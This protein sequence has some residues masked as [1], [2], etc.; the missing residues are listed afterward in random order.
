MHVFYKINNHYAY[1]TGKKLLE[2]EEG[3]HFVDCKFFSQPVF[4]EFENKKYY[5]G[6]FINDTLG[7]EILDKNSKYL[8]CCKDEQKKYVV[9]GDLGSFSFDY[10]KKISSDRFY[11][12]TLT[13]GYSQA[14]RFKHFHK[15]LLLRSLF[16][17][18]A[19]YS[20]SIYAFQNYCY[21][22]DFVFW[23]YNP[24]TK[25]FCSAASSVEV[26]KNFIEESDNSSLH[27]FLR[28]NIPF[29]TRAP[30][31]GCIN[32]NVASGKLTLNRVRL[33]FV[34][35]DEVGV[36]DFFSSVKDFTLRKDTRILIKNH[37]ESKY[38]ENKT[39]SDSS[40]HKIEEYFTKYL[41]GKLHRFL[42]ELTSIVCSELNFQIC[43]IFEKEEHAN[44][45]ILVAQH[46]KFEKVFNVKNIKYDLS[47]KSM[48]Q[49]VYKSGEW[50]Y[51]YNIEDDPRNTHTYDEKTD[52]IGKTWMAFPLQVGEKK[53]GVLRV[54]NKHSKQDKG[55]LENFTANDYFVLNSVCTHLSNI[56]MLEEKHKENISK[57]DAL[58]GKENKLEKD[59]EELSNFYNVFLHEIR[60]PISTFNTSPLRIKMLLG[61]SGIESSIKADIEKKIS[62][63][64]MMAGRLKFIADTYYFDEL[65]ESR[66]PK[67]VRVLPEIVIPVLNI[68]RDYIKHQ[69]EVDIKYDPVSFHSYNVY[70]DI[71]LLNLVFNT[72][73]SNAA[74]YSAG[75]GRPIQITSEVDK[76]HEYFYLCVS[77]YGLH[78]NPKEREDVFKNRVRGQNA[79]DQDIGGTGIGLYLAKRIMENQHGDVL[80]TSLGEPVTFKIKMSMDKWEA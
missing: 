15:D 51:S 4:D 7:S 44:N 12:V 29:D 58:K 6:A 9:F 60:T 50:N 20:D 22:D 30:Q 45:L 65:V 38:I 8:Y 73:I 39:A 79:I 42:S 57:L 3:D 32:S 75:S 27:E 54:K 36:L 67:S 13:K 63:I 74:K 40:L 26:S 2:A 25:H 48:T 10:I 5:M 43:S 64:Q 69:Y 28:K 76:N 23:I 49:E 18:K 14:T 46:N 72:L 80:L 33:D 47:K 1:F 35:T 11:R 34:S 77:N 41:P 62:D 55:E 78:I 61:S 31:S 19:S 53:W 16:E 52:G 24:H 21:F 71:I 68:S 17:N 56:F 66:N 70:G 59:L 37:I